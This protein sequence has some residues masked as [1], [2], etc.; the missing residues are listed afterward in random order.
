MTYLG[1]DPGLK[2]TAL[3]W[4]DFTPAP[5]VMRVEV[6]VSKA[7]PATPGAM[8][9]AVSNSSQRWSPADVVV[10]ESQ[11]VY[12][13]RGQAGRK[14]GDGR[15]QPKVLIGLAHVSGAVALAAGVEDI[16]LPEPV[17]WKGNL[18]KDVYHEAVLTALGQGWE[19]D[20][21]ESASQRRLVPRSPPV[22]SDLPGGAWQHVLDAVGLCLWAH[23]GK[24]WRKTVMTAPEI[25]GRRSWATRAKA[26]PDPDGLLR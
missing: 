25:V 11:Q 21:V 12:D 2:Q 26:L 16:R 24:G 6:V 10:A 3:A 9:W 18:A 13:K 5:L 15:V 14:G 22:G 8:I 20:V 23:Q 19:W 7:S 17:E 1:C 4:V